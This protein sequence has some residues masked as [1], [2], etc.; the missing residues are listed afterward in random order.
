MRVELEHVFQASFNIIHVYIVRYDLDLI[1]E[2]RVDSIAMKVTRVA[3]AERNYLRGVLR[4]FL[5]GKK[6]QKYVIGCFRN[7]PIRVFDAVA[8]ELAEHSHMPR[9]RELYQIRKRLQNALESRESKTKW[10]PWVL[11]SY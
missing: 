8:K 3:V 11:S 10:S 2:P 5:L 7:V 9:F 4:A 1:V 6:N